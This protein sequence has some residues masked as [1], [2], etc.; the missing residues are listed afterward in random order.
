[1]TS[2]MSLLLICSRSRTRF[3]SGNREQIIAISPM[4]AFSV[5]MVALEHETLDSSSMKETRDSYG[6]EDCTV[7][8]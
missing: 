7:A 5:S 8:L 6:V 3:K 2:S 1:M 4:K